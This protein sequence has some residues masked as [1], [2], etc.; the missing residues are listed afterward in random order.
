MALTK[1]RMAK[2]FPNY[3]RTPLNSPYPH[4]I[5]LG[6]VF[7]N[8]QVVNLLV[9]HLFKFFLRLLVFCQICI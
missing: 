4:Q 8:Q 7:T 6:A 9:F 1:K 2:S 5:D 3:I